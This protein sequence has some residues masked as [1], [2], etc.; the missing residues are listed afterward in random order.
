MKKKE[1]RILKQKNGPVAGLAESRYI[2]TRRHFWV[3]LSG[4]SVHVCHSPK[5][6]KAAWRKI[7]ASGWQKKVT[8]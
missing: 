1:A 6:A 2:G 5:E 3:V 7:N 8:P 4:F